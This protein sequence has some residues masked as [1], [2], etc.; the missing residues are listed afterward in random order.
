MTGCDSGFGYSSLAGYFTKNIGKNLDFH[1]SARSTAMMKSGTAT[2]MWVQSVGGNICLRVGCL[3]KCWADLYFH[4]L[5]D[6]LVN[7]L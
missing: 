6:H 4:R 1:D 7:L 2:T 3:L 5:F